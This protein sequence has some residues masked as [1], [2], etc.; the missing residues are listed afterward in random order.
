MPKSVTC[1]RWF[2]FVR[3]EGV[4]AYPLLS[5]GAAIPEPGGRGAVAGGAN[6]A[7]K[8]YFAKTE[9]HYTFLAAAFHA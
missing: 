4:P 1:G 8:P 2:L 9:R 5:F 3:G 6:C 7:Q